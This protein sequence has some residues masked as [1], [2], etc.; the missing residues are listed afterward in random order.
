MADASNAVED[1]RAE[2]ASLYGLLADIRAAVGDN[3]K[4]MQADLVEWLREVA[5]ND[6]RYRWLREQHEGQD[7]GETFCVFEPDYGAHCLEPVGSM[8]G[9]LDAAID[10][11]IRASSPNHSVDA[12]KMGGGDCAVG[13]EEVDHG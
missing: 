1:L 2:N 13:G 11:A 10:A 8:P 7:S 4:R 9:E 12:N 5:A 3:G 6:R